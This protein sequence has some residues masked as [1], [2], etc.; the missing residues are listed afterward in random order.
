M[1]AVPPGLRWLKGSRFEWWEVSLQHESTLSHNPTQRMLEELVFAMGNH[2]QPQR[3]G[4]KGRLSRFEVAQEQSWPFLEAMGLKVAAGKQRVSRA[5]SSSSLLR[6]QGTPHIKSPKRAT[7]GILELS[8]SQNMDQQQDQLLPLQEQG[9]YHVC[10]C[11]H[12][13]CL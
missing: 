9:A 2:S 8:E 4:I 6:V 10:D 1:S 5:L 13:C 3:E 7:K 12:S 11:C